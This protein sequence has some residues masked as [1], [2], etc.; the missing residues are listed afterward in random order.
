MPYSAIAFFASAV[1]AADTLP[2]AVYL[3]LGEA[4]GVAPALACWPLRPAGR[5]VAE[6][7]RMI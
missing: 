1:D 5:D 6:P 4:V 7:P 2:S 3:V